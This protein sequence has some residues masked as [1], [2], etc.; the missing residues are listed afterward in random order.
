MELLPFG[1]RAILINFEQKIEPAINDQVIALKQL[2]NESQIDGLKD[3]IP[4][5]CSLTVVYDPLEASYDKLC[6]QILQLAQLADK[7]PDFKSQTFDIPVCYGDEFGPDLEDLSEDIG[8]TPDD[9]TST[10]TSLAFRVYMIGFLPGFVYMGS[11]PDSLKCNRKKTP[12]LKVPARSVGLAGIQTGIYPSEAP[13]GWQIIGRTPIRIFNAKNEQPFLFKAG[14]QVKFHAI[15]K[16]EYQ[17][18]EADL[19]RGKFDMTSI[20]VR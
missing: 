15:S 19:D 8:V 11:L 6:D 10:H 20:Y 1:D 9:I 2:L 12:R 5:Y 3:T 4:A 7:T 16:D 14:D 17:E 13:G 18:I